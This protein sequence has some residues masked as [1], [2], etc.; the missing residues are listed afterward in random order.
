MAPDP[1]LI[2]EKPFDQSLFRDGFAVPQRAIDGFFQSIG[3]MLSRGQALEISIW[4]RG[5]E[6]TATAKSFTMQTAPDHADMVQ[7]RYR[8][9]DPLPRRLRQAFPQASAYFERAAGSYPPRTHIRLPAELEQSV[10]VCRLGHGKLGI[11]L[12]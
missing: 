10:L 8:R 5:T 6:Y 4:F 2:F 9:E 1:L 3:K 11:E 12:R 7:V